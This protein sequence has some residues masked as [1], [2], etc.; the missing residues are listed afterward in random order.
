MTR[1][2]PAHLLHRQ[3]FEPLRQDL[4]AWVARRLRERGPG[5]MWN[6]PAPEGLV[7]FGPP[8]AGGPLLLR[9]LAE[10]VDP[11]RLLPVRDLTE[12]G[13]VD[14][15]EQVSVASTS[16]DETLAASLAGGGWDSYRKVTLL[17]QD[18]PFP[19][20]LA[21]V[22]ATNLRAPDGDELNVRP[23]LDAFRA[24]ILRGVG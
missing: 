12:R 3:G 18:K 9:V 2:D 15:L 8:S 21:S 5:W 7:F 17:R 1:H 20:M 14:A 19:S 24:W 10:L 22:I 4:R 6:R 11:A 16:Q 13:L 23:E